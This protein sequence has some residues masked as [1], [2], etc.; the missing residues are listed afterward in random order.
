MPKLIWKAVLCIA[1][2]GRQASLN[3]WAVASRFLR[4]F[5]DT[6]HALRTEVD[7]CPV[8]ACGTCGGK[9]GQLGVKS[10]SGHL[11]WRAGPKIAKRPKQ[12]DPGIQH[13][14]PP[15][16][17]SLPSL[18]PPKSTK[19][20]RHLGGLCF[21]RVGVTLFRTPPGG[22][23]RS[24]KGAAGHLGLHQLPGGNVTT[25]HPSHGPQVVPPHR[26]RVRGR[27]PPER[28]MRGHPSWLERTETCELGSQIR[29]SVLKPTGL[30]SGLFWDAL[31]RGR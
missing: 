31:G 14:K 7:A 4:N 29:R 8:L 5:F 19:H 27:V 12:L 24:C 18:H 22:H 10:V 17:P 11:V 3:H 26:A 23:P 16:T 1:W 20:S 30:R 21:P 6:P 9:S 13:L 28:A 15:G 25:S 2:I